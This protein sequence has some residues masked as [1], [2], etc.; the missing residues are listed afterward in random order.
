MTEWVNVHSKSIMSDSNNS[1]G[2]VERGLAHYL[3]I[4]IEQNY[5]MIGLLVD[6]KNDINEIK[7]RIYEST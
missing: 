4:L 5:S 7:E 6:L 3:S 2:G 1:F